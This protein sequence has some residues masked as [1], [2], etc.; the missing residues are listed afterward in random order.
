MFKS[1]DIYHY[2]CINEKRTHVFERQRLNITMP[3]IHS[4]IP[5]AKH[6]PKTPYLPGGVTLDPSQMKTE[7][8]EEIIRLE[9]ES[10]LNF[11][12]PVMDLMG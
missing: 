11:E 9:E 1:N 2:F 7:A 4:S 5:I 10:R 6:A 12:M 3:R 8:Q